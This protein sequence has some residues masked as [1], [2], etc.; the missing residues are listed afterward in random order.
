MPVFSEPIQLSLTHPEI[1]IFT[2]LAKHLA[3]FWYYSLK[4]SDYTHWIWSTSRNAGGCLAPPK[5]SR[6]CQMV[7]LMYML[8]NIILRITL[9]RIKTDKSKDDNHLRLVHKKGYVTAP[10]TRKTSQFW[11][12]LV[13]GCPVTFTT[14]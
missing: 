6:R 5:L 8:N 2:V 13:Y 4:Y 11:H 9:H 7:N 10:I 12:H 1:I 3:C 14:L